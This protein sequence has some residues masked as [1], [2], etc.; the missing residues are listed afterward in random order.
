M[1]CEI[2]D[3]RKRLK[4]QN[5]QWQLANEDD[6]QSKSVTK[7]IVLKI[8]FY[9]RTDYRRNNWKHIACLVQNN[10]FQKKNIGQN[11]QCPLAN[12]D[13]LQSKTVMKKIVLRIVFYI[14]MNYRHYHW[15][16]FAC[17]SR[18]QRTQKKT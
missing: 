3:L 5:L 2:T 10:R 11:L 12:E 14:G 15:T 8:V 1:Y 6:L 16:H 4:G 18:N 7:E 17:V 9:I 13:D